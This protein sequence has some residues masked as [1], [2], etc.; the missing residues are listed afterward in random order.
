MQ[1]NGFTS[2]LHGEGSYVCNRAS[3]ICRSSF[4]AAVEL[5]AN[6][7]PFRYRLLIFYIIIFY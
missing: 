3:D 2:W 7:L 4:A 5:L 6:P 1:V